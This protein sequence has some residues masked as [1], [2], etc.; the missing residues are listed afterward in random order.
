MKS[1]SLYSTM[2][3]NDLIKFGWHRMDTGGVAFLKLPAP[4]GPIFLAD[5]QKVIGYIPPWLTN[6]S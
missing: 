6:L 2:V 1:N 3:A 5:R 4:Y